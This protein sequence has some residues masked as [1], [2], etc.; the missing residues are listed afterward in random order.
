MSPGYHLRLTVANLLCINVLGGLYLTAERR[1]VA[2]A[3][4]QPRR[5]AVLA[6]LA[7]AGERAVSREQF[8]NYLWPDTDEERGRHALTQALYA[9][10]HDLEADQ[11]FLGQQ[12]IRLNPDLI[13]SDYAAFQAAIRAQEPERAVECYRGPFLEGFS[14]PRADNFA[15]WAEDQRVA[16]AHDYGRMLEAAARRATGRRDFEA[17]TGYLRRRAALDPLDAGVAVRLMEALA[18]QG[19]VVAALQH[20]RVHETLVQQE[21]G[22]PPDPEVVALAERI[23]RGPRLAPAPDVEPALA[24]SPGVSAAGP[25]DPGQAGPSTA[26]AAPPP[27]PRRWLVPAALA[28]VAVAGAGLAL[29]RSRTPEAASASG[30][31]PVMAVGLIADYTGRGPGGLG[32]P[33]ADMLATNLARGSGFRVIS[34]ARMLEL[35]RQLGASGESAGA[36]S[37]AARQAGAAQLIDGALYAIAPNRYRLDLR[38]VDLASGAVVR[39]YRV[40]GEDLFVLAD[41]GTV[42]LVADLGGAAPT[43]SLAEASTRSVQAYQLYS[44]GLRRFYDYEPVIAERLFRQALDIDSGFAQAAFYYARATTSGSRTE[45][46][47]RLKRA[48]ELSAHASDRERL[49]IEAEWFL[50]NSSPELA[51]V[52]DTLMHRYPAEIDGYYY[53]AQGE[54]RLGHFLAAEAPFRRVLQLDSLGVTDV[55]TGRCRTCEAFGGLSYIY[56]A[57]DS[58]AWVRSTIRDWVHRQPGSSQA[59]LGLATMYSRDKQLDSSLAALRISDSLHP[60]GANYRRQQV[61]M[62]SGAEDYAGAEQLLRSE[63]ESGPTISQADAKWDLAVTLRQMGRLREALRL[64][65]D[66]RMHIRERLLPGAAPYN[67][68]LEAQIHFELGQPR[69]AAAMFDSIAVGQEGDFTESLRSRDRIWAW[70]HEADALAELGDTSRLRL[71]ADSMEILGRKVAHARDQV[72]HA[73]VRG[74]LARLQGRDE[75]AA[76]WFRRAIVSPVF[77]FT[78]SNYELAGACLRTHRPAEAIATLRSALHGSF[79]DS[80]LYITRPELQIR[81]AEAFDSA[82]QADSAR[83][84]RRR[85][86]QAWEHAEPPISA[87]RDSIALAVRE[88]DPSSRR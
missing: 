65:H 87:R 42:G 55:Q 26:V 74:L 23:R 52:A 32:R 59:W 79:I 39:A 58:M 81:I 15:R 27:Q 16:L 36:V 46:L 70:V 50:E 61:A 21:L 73:H 62:R 83:Y 38:R 43:G 9:L 85:V 86:L 88:L 84:Y 5:L 3:A 1:L 47:D 25:G 40:E 4:T 60:Y 33:L 13:T 8:L 51:A 57:I 75:A 69:V 77:G 56:A 53:A 71:L 37:T 82:G 72:L 66:Y 64:A 45:T 11:L 18:A 14:L 67:A 28:L 63:V 35:T 44:E 48:V 41:S 76:V 30:G 78:R 34:N 19:A 17:A 7:V 20:A 49:V 31:R 24:G 80:N 29:F 54:A 2:G 6:L 10:R 12:D 68:L 22:L